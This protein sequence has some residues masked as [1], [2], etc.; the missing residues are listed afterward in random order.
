VVEA[1]PI[2]PIF[3]GYL[4]AFNALVFELSFYPDG[5]DAGGDLLLLLDATMGRVTH[6]KMTR[7]ATGCNSA[8]ALSRDGRT[9]LTSTEIL[10]ANGRS[11]AID[12]RPGREVAGTLLVN[13]QTVL[14]TYVGGYDNKGDQLPLKGPN[15][16][17]MDL[18]GRKLAA[19]NL[20]SIDGGL[21]SRM[22]SK[23]VGQTRTHY[24]F[25][26]VNGKIGLVSAK[27]PTPARILKLSEVPVFRA[28]Q[29]PTEVR[30][31]FATETG[32]LATFYV[33]TVSGNLRHRISKPTY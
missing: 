3:S 1:T 27:Q 29:H 20:E 9:L 13:D 16:E 11:T 31:R 32:A 28:P 14:V 15:A 23:Y 10:Q 2:L 8:T 26:E 18:N 7:W 30:I 33:D 25:D 17:L 12:N 22:L 4:P 19:F 24:L 21:G 6:K 5:S